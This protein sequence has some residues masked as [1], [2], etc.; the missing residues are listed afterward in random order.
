MKLKR[1]NFFLEIIIGIIA[2][3]LSILI[4]LFLFQ[5]N[6]M[7]HPD[8]NNYFCDKLVVEI[9]KVNIKTSDDINLL[10]WFHNKNLEK[11][12]KQN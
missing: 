3:Y 5:R 7:Y 4:L 10:G 6:L 9:E 8:E 2:I 11:Y 1:R 12:K